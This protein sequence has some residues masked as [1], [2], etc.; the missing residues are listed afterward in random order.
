MWFVSR[1]T[2]V[3]HPCR[4]DESIVTEFPA[5][6]QYLMVR[7]CEIYEDIQSSLCLEQPVDG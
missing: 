4:R 7:Y 5:F 2:R 6:A 3:S 1:T